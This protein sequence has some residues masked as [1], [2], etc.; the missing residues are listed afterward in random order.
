MQILYRDKTE[1]IWTDFK[2]ENGISI[3]PSGSI[4]VSIQYQSDATPRVA[5]AVATHYANGQYFYEIDVDST[6]PYGYYGA[7]W[8]ADQSGLILAADVPNVFKIESTNESIIKGI[9]LERVRSQL[10]MHEDMGGFINKFPR[11]RELLDHL[12]TSL[13]WWNAYPP[14]ITF[15]SF[16]D[17]PQPY[18]S[19]I[20]EGAV[21]NALVAIGVFEAGKHFIYNDNGISLTRD[22]SGKYQAIFNQLMTSYIQNLKA[23]RTKYA[24]DHVIARGLFSSTTGFPRSLS[25]ALRGVSKFA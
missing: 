12:Q 20:E 9:M 6:W 22:R 13:N 24:L 1:R 3:Q 5:A 17:V 11:N 14:A 18:Y 15:H 25:R 16:L 19:I 8:Q 23:M 4:T 21:I 10:Y 2:D 7:F